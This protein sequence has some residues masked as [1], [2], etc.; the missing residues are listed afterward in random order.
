MLSD[1]SNYE[2]IEPL[3]GVT[4]HV[5]DVQAKR[6]LIHIA[7]QVLLGN[8]MVNA[9]HSALEHSPDRFNAVRADSV[10]GVLPSRVIDGLVAKEQT[11]KADVS[12]CFIRKDRRTDFD[13]GV[14][15]A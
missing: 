13:V 4:A 14:D 9:I 6:E 5:A 7:V 15:R 11:V 1:Y 2:A 12:S 10:L 3:Q 8:L